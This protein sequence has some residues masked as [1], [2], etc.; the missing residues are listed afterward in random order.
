MDLDAIKARA[1]AWADAD[2]DPATKAEIVAL[3]DAPDPK[4]TDLPDRFGA[5]LEFGTAGLRGVIGGGTNR[6]NRAV[7]LRTTWGLGRF[8]L[9]K[10]PEAKPRGV[11]IGYDGRRMSRELAEDTA[12]V[13]AGAGIR[14]KIGSNGHCPVE[15][16]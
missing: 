8:L 7:V 11:V 13:L 5:S 2:P 4:Q 12:C 14:A 6:M 16:P 9:E 10:E 15:L 3:L 1:R